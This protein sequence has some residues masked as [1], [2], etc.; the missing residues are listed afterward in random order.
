MVDYGPVAILS[1]PL[2]GLHYPYYDNTSNR[3]KFRYPNEGHGRR[4]RAGRGRRLIRLTLHIKPL[5]INAAT[6]GRHYPTKAKTAY[7]AALRYSLPKVFVAGQPYYRIS[8]DFHLV[9]FALT[10]LDNCQKITQD[11]LVKRGIITE[12]RLI[13]NTRLRK[14][15]AAKDRIEIKIEACGANREEDAI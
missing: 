11:C 5:S 14:F 13:V 6:R 15:K 4:G 7:E 1:L 12:D 9:N 2:M 8:Y 10:D 3:R